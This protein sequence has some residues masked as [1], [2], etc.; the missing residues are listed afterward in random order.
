MSR[1]GSEVLGQEQMAAVW[2]C[3]GSPWLQSRWKFQELPFD[4]VFEHLKPQAGY[5]L[6]HLGSRKFRVVE[7]AQPQVLQ[8]CFDVLGRS[9]LRSWPGGPQVS[10]PDVD[11]EIRM[12]HSKPF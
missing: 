11:T 5:I 7:R 3:D 6:A 4:L 1:D 8:T 2:D 10:S 9:F 12:H